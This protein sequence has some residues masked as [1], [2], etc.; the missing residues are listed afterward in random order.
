MVPITYQLTFED[1]EGAFPVA[2]EATAF[3][4]ESRRKG[5]DLYDLCLPGKIDLEVEYLGSITAH[6]IPGRQAQPQAGL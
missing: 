4:D 5:R 2:V 6:L 1:G 3:E